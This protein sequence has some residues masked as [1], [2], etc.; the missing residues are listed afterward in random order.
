M[1]YQE[2]FSSKNEDNCDCDNTTMDLNNL[3]INMIT[4]QKSLLLDIIDGI[5]DKNK[6]R[7]LIEKVLLTSNEKKLE[8]KKEA[9]VNLSYS[10]KFLLE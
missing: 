9:L 3:N 10:L 7:Q 1:L 2:S 4:A 5:E 6:Q 8:L